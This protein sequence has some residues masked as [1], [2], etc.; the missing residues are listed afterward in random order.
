VR[1][2]H[3]VADISLRWVYLHRVKEY[4]R[5]NAHADLLRERIDGA[6]GQ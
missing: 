2:Q 3:E 4:A 1:R 6:T 5:H